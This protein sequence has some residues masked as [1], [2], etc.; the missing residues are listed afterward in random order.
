MPGWL[1]HPVGYGGANPLRH[2]DP[3]GQRPCDVDECEPDW[4][5]PPPPP[6]PDFPAGDYPDMNEP[7]LTVSEPCSGC[8]GSVLARASDFTLRL[9]GEYLYV[10]VSAAGGG[11]FI[12]GGGAVKNVRHERTV[13]IEDPKRFAEELFESP[14]KGM[15]PQ[16][17]A[18]DR[19]PGGRQVQLKDG[20]IV[21]IRQAADGCGRWMFGPAADTSR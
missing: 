15:D 7:P 20:S 3:T 4:R 12:L 19:Y 5:P 2:T 11:E 8:G 10:V 6:P 14:T 17:Y 21:G 18:P 16:P 13:Q 9:V 1:G